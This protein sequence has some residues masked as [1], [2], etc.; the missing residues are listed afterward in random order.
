MASLIFGVELLTTV[1]DRRATLAAAASA[2]L[3]VLRTAQ[4]PGGM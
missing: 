2:F 4:L 1:L 3:V